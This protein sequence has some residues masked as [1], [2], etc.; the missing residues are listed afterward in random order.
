MTVDW[1]CGLKFDPTNNIL[2]KILLDE[3]L[4]KKREDQQ[5][6]VITTGALICVL[7]FKDYVI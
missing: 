4:I 6:N 3:V 1:N 7:T 5:K 2:I